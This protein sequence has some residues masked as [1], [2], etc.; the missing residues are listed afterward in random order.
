MCSEQY[1]RVGI[2]H[3]VEPGRE[4]DKPG[5]TDIIRVIV[6]H[7]FFATQGVDNWRFQFSGK[8]QELLCAP[9]QPLPHIRAMLLE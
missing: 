5:H 9:A 6:F 4:I 7:V 1:Q 2:H 3:G 8:F